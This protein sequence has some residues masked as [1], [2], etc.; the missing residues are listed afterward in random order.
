MVGRGTSLGKNVFVDADVLV[1]EDVRVQNN[2]SIYR[3]VEL[4][5]GVFVGPSAVFTNDLFPRAGSRDWAPVPT[6]VA[7]GASIGANATIVCG[8]SIGPWSLVGA[9]AVVTRDVKAHEIVAGNPARNVG[10]VCECGATRTGGDDVL[11]VCS[12]CGTNE[13]LCLE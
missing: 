8:V 12:E 10:W 11:L 1:G 2:V 3:G 7:R 5:D 9:G 4:A 13:S 6:K